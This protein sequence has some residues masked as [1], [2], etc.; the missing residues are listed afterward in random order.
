MRR[1][2]KMPTPQGKGAGQTAT[3]KLPLG[4]TYHTL[5]IRAKTAAGVD[6]T[7]A[8]WKN[9]IGDVR[10]SVNGDT[11]IEADAAYLVADSLFYGQTLVNGVL[12][13]HLSQPWARTKEGEENTAYGTSQNMASFTLEIDQ[14]NALTNFEV[15]AVQSEARPFGA[16]LRVQKFVD[17]MTLTGTKEVSDLPRGA[18]NLLGA[19]INSASIDVVEVLANNLKV[20]E[21][22]KAIRTAEQ[23]TIGRVAQAGF[24]HIDLMSGNQLG[25]ALPMALNDFR[26]KLD[27]TA[28]PNS[29]EIYTKSIQGVV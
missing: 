19:H 14:I 10:V 27:F 2:Q 21:S 16:H 25:N 3:V 11:R 17:Q 7:A 15:F 1:L 20:H 8:N 9:E 5:F 4:P 23:K 29:Y 6:I 12:P 24:T 18:Y 13:I 28:A 26:L 22:D